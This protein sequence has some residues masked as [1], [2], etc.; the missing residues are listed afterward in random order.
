MKINADLHTHTVFS[1]GK[2]TIE[3]NVRSARKKGLKKIVISDH[4]SGH[5]FYGV[6]PK[7]WVEMRKEVNRLQKVYPDMEILLGVEANVVGLDGSIDVSEE[8]RKLLDTVYVGYHYGIKPRG[9]GSFL[10]FYI[11]NGLAKL[12]P[13]LRKPIKRLNTRAL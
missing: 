6:D 12:L 1:H 4:G 10:W 13:F 11:G 3:E 9:P 2:N 5:L 8:Q 7:D